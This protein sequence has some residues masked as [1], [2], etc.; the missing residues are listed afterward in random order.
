MRYF[1][2]GVDVTT[3][4]VGHLGL[5]ERTALAMAKLY[6]QTD[7]AG[8]SA[9]YAVRTN[10]SIVGHI[11]AN[12]P[13]KIDEVDMANYQTQMVANV[14]TFVRDHFPNVR[15]SCQAD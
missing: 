7:L 8:E 6:Y 1:I 15:F 14:E 3:G 10:V 11:E 2:D 9:R 13:L 4:S 5:E 12:L